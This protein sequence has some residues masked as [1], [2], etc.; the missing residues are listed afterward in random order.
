MNVHDMLP[1][2]SPK[3]LLAAALVCVL[4]C[5]PDPPAFTI[6]TYQDERGRTV[7]HCGHDQLRCRQFLAQVCA[8]KPRKP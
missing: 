4:G 7:L 5:G 6:V 2:K 3:V 8:A 1:T